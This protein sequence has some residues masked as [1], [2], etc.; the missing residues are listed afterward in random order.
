MRTRRINTVTHA[1]AAWNIRCHHA[2]MHAEDVYEEGVDTVE[3]VTMLGHARH[4]P[5]PPASTR[6]VV[7]GGFDGR[8]HQSSRRERARRR[9]PR[10]PALRNAITLESAIYRCKPH[11]SIFRSL[12]PPLLGAGII[13]LFIGNKSGVGRSAGRQSRLHAVRLIYSRLDGRAIII[14]RRD[15]QSPELS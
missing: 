2:R 5:T 14:S 10:L 15:L 3:L 8:H 13:L 11:F 6:S 1:I 7:D 4:T 9:R 12:I